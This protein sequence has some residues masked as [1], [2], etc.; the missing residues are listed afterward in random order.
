L[1]T[2]AENHLNSHQSQPNL[3]TSHDQIYPPLRYYMR[4]RVYR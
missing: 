3:D 4:Q 2:D 1:S